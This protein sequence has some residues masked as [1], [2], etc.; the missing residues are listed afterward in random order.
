MNP[1]LN[2]ANIAIVLKCES[3]MRLNDYRPISV[4]NTMYKVISKILA[5]RFRPLLNLLISLNQSA[6]VKGQNIG[7]NSLVVQELV[8]T[9][10]CKKGKLGL[11]LIKLDMEKA[12]DHLEWSFIRTVLL[13]VGFP[14]RFIN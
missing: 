9:L 8:H 2:E 13:N 14:Y 10:R 6:F 12:Y 4:Y 5:N 11:M 7:E 1:K 3:P